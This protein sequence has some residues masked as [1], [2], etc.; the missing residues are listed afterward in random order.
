MEGFQ[1]I[2]FHGPFT[3]ALFK[4]CFAGVRVFYGNTRQAILLHL[5]AR[6]ASGVSLRSALG[7]Y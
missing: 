7:A 2:E 6:E 1:G 5:R 3:V 4:A